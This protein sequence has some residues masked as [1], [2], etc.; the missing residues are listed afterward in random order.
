MKIKHLNFTTETGDITTFYTERGNARPNDPYSETNCCDYTNDSPLH[1]EYCRKELCKEL[2]IAENHLITA[3]QTHGTEVRII[4]SAFLATPREE[5]LK[6]LYGTD[7]LVTACQGVA[8]A[9]FTAD[10]VPILLY[11]P[12]KQII[13]AVHAGWKGTLHAIAAVAVAKMES[14]GANP[15]RIEATFGAAI[16]QNCFET[17][18]E[19]ADQFTDAGFP[20][21]RIMYRNAT[22]GKAHIDLIEANC[23][24]LEKSGLHESSIVKSGLCTK[25][26]PDRFFS[27]R[28]LGINSGRII[29]GIMINNRK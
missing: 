8:V 23:H 21:Q 25:C 14:L 15:Q 9:V 4:D 6:S 12:E 10:C 26:N 29:T 13:A 19:V 22:T 18:D 28:V 5:Q 16:C 3:R 7:G 11:E 17:G 1:Y 2:G 27:A 24:I 20:M